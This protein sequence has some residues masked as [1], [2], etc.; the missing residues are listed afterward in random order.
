MAGS[1]VVQPIFSFTIPRGEDCDTICNIYWWCGDWIPVQENDADVHEPVYD[2][3]FDG[4]IAI[5]CPCRVSSSVLDCITTT[6]GTL[7]RTMTVVIGETANTTNC[8]CLEG[9]AFEIDYDP[10]LGYWTGL[11][12]APCNGGAQMEAR[13]HCDTLSGSYLLG[14]YCASGLGGMQLIHSSEVLVCDGDEDFKPCCCL[15]TPPAGYESSAVISRIDRILGVSTAGTDCSCGTTTEIWDTW[16]LAD[17]CCEEPTV[18]CCT[19]CDDY[20]ENLLID[21]DITPGLFG[22]C[23]VGG[24]TTLTQYLNDDTHC[25][26]RGSLETECTN[27][28]K[29]LWISISKGLLAFADTVPCDSWFLSMHCTNGS[30]PPAD[31]FSWSYGSHSLTV[32]DGE[33][34]DCCEWSLTMHET[35]GGGLSI[36]CCAV[37]LPVPSICTPSRVDVILQAIG[38]T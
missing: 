15:L 19:D 29:V 2:G 26:W 23:P 16:V 11:A 31:V 34:L 5:R 1:C 10:D 27:T 28:T 7:P 12:S 38:C 37:T 3:S 8:D 25:E 4:E 36:S 9:V 30:D 35:N 17:G 32:D 14:I 33:T 21:I 18:C 24:N 22:A 13:I 20:P 6:C